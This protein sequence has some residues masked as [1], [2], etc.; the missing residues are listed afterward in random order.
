MI[1]RAQQGHGGIQRLYMD[2]ATT[3]FTKTVGAPS[4]RRCFD[5]LEVIICTKADIS[6]QRA[7]KSAVKADKSELFYPI[8]VDIYSFGLGYAMASMSRMTFL[9]SCSR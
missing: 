5:F 4:Q 3:V 1:D 2:K 6:T 9:F 8:K 7:D